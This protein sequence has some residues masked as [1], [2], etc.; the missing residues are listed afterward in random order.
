MSLPTDFDRE[1]AALVDQPGFDEVLARADRNRRRRRTTIASGLAAAAVVAGVAA[2]GQAQW[3][4]GAPDPAG[5][6]PSDSATPL[7]GEVD[8]RLPEAVRDLL[9]SERIH[10]WQVAG[11]GGAI[12]VL[13]GAC[14]DGDGCRFAVVTRLG[15]RV[16]STFLAGPSPTIAEVP[17]GWLVQDT[18]SMFRLS[19]EGE[20]TQVSARGD[21]VPVEA[22][23]TAVETSDGWRLLRDETLLPV[24]TP[25]GSYALAAY[26]TPAG[27]LVVATQPSPVTVEVSWTD[28]S[29]SWQSGYL[30]RTTGRVGGVVLAGHHDGVAVALLGDSPDGS[31]PV[32]D[33]AVSTD[34][35]RSWQSGR[36][37]PAGLRDLSAL[38]VSDEGAAYLTTGSHGTVRVDADGNALAVG[39]SPHDR[40]A[41]QVSHRV[42]LVAETGRVDELRC[43]A[44]DGAT[45]TALSLPGFR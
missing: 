15:D 7:T 45:W 40:S 37:L 22:G 3:G 28:A 10:P 16:A 17:G 34:A 9:G 32:L 26:V 14:P 30:R 38:A 36:G 44:D 8:E 29:G 31:L 25:D 21:Q 27:D 18:S 42:C 2:W 6:R 23:D 1:I 35:G 20:R 12:A 5:P 4:D 33:V 24:P 39:Q 11:S 43:S 19:P 13:W 41:F